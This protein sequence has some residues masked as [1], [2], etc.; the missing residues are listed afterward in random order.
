LEVRE[1]E[2]GF[3]AR[4]WCRKEFEQHGLGTEFVQ[5]NL[6]HNKCKGT[7]RGLHFQLKPFAEAKL[8][9]C[10]RG[11]VWDV[12]VDL[13]RDSST[14]MKWFGVELSADNRRQLYVPKN[15]AHGYQTLVDDAEV[16]YHVSEFYTPD[17][18]RGIRWDDPAFSIHWPQSTGVVVSTKDQSWPA[19]T[20][21]RREGVDALS[22]IRSCHIQNT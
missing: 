2:R 7:I 16:L 6:S 10:I 9:R 22:S 14:Y 13:R 20:A 1:D 18:E 3:F 15:F 19:F 8:V 12:I 21:E 17:Y 11:A 4:T 5:A